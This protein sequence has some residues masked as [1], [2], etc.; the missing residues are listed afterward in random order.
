M[1]K[2]NTHGNKCALLEIFSGV[3]EKKISVINNAF[4]PDA[5]LESDGGSVVLSDITYTGEIYEG[6]LDL[7]IEAVCALINKGSGFI[8]RLAVYGRLDPSYDK[9]LRESPA[10][11]YIEYKGSVS[12]DKSIEIMRNSNTLLLALPHTERGRTW[13]PSKLYAYLF[14]GRP[15][16]AIC[17]DGDA[18]RIIEETRTGAALK[19]DSPADL[20][21][22]I[23]EFFNRVER[24]DYEKE[25]DM[26]SI[27]KYSM[28]H[29]AQKLDKILLKL[30]VA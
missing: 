11:K 7:Y 21:G 19:S 20:A 12:F 24:A 9:I 25:R 8:P 23:I 2:A 10:G 6:M 29:L 3:D 17:P 5:V 1:V 18:S 30:S 27:E 13:I 16:L 14:W 4:D 22:E 15:I 28:K 26:K